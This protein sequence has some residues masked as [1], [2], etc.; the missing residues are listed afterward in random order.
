MKGY[1]NL[2]VV[3]DPRQPETLQHIDLICKRIKGREEK[4]CYS[5]GKWKDKEMDRK[6]QPRWLSFFCFILYNC[7]DWDFY[8]RFPEVG[9]EVKTAAGGKQ[10]RI[11]LVRSS[12]R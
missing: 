7:I 6:Q 5:L 11:N 4:K 10:D 1:L 3:A 12:Q 8:P 2:V 9:K